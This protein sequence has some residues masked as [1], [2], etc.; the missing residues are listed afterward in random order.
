MS[1]KYQFVNVNKTYFGV[2]ELEIQNEM[3]HI[4]I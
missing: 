2:K 3:K 1:W 4:I